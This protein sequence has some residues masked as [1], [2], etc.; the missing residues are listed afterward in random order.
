MKD[1]RQDLNVL[2]VFTIDKDNKAELLMGEI[3]AP[4]GI[5][6]APD[7]KTIYITDTGETGNIFVFDVNNN[8]ISNK[9]I[10]ATPRPTN[11]ME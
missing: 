2:M 8:K 1:M 6:F 11:Q 5:A 10:F 7:E 3:D 4:N 9:R